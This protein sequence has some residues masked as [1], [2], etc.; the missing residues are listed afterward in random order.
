ME[1]INNAVLLDKIRELGEEEQLRYDEWLKKKDGYR[2]VPCEIFYNRNNVPKFYDKESIQLKAKILYDTLENNGCEFESYIGGYRENVY[3]RFVIYAKEGYEKES[4]EKTI[5]EVVSSKSD[6]ITIEKDL[7][8]ADKIVVNIYATSLYKPCLR[9]FL[10][11]SFLIDTD[12]LVIPIGKK[13]ADEETVYCDI[14]K[15]A[16]MFI[17]GEKRGEV[18]SCI[19]AMLLS[20]LCKA[21]PNEVRMMMVDTIGD[22]LPYYNGIPHL[23]SPCFTESS[24]GVAVIKW[25]AAEMNRRV[26]LYR[27]RGMDD[28]HGY[29]DQVDHEGS[30]TRIPFVL[31]IVTDLADLIRENEQESV[32][33]LNNMPE[34]Y[35]RTGVYIVS[36][37][38]IVR[39][40]ELQ[41]K[42]F[43]YFGGRAVLS[44]SSE[45][46]SQALLGCKGAEA[47]TE[48][49][50]ILYAPLAFPTPIKCR[51]IEVNQDEVTN[52]VK[53]L[54]ENYGSIYDDNVIEEINRLGKSLQ[55]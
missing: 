1:R 9:E 23:L 15:Q 14:S 30:G 27:S 29:N 35:W 2:P 45:D 36:A 5:K 28:I 44:V 22:S 37:S 47:L 39:S 31:V 46:M 32:K 12:P 24:K 49:Y 38:S 19:D 18:L 25:A 54:T 17:A 26:E 55:K 4:M 40:E 33:A 7:T 20:I 21:S 16:N 52:A 8:L 10:F 42:V 6:R 48:E 41:S 11:N 53:Y 50:D 13:Y 3:I 51:G 34:M 43:N